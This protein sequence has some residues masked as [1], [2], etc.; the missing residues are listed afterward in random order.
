MLS[1]N[2]VSSFYMNNF[3]A[4]I[5]APFTSL[6][7]YSAGVI[8]QNGNI[9]KPESSID[10]FEYL[11]IKLKKIFAELP[12]GITKAKL[13]SYIPTLQ[14]FSEEAEGFGLDK[15]SVNLLI[16]GF[17]TA[18]TKGH[19]SY[20][21]LT[22]DM[23]SANLGGPASSPTANTG[24]V[25]GFDLPMGGI[26][27]RKPQQSVLGFEKQSCEMYDVCPEDYDLLANPNL[28]SWDEVPDSETK[29]FMQR[30]QRRNGGSTI[31]IRDTGTNR[32]H[33]VNLVPR[34]ISKM[35][36]NVDLS[37]FKSLLNEEGATTAYQDD[38][39]QKENN[40]AVET[41]EQERRELNNP[42]HVKKMAE[43]HLLSL[44]KIGQGQSKNASLVGAAALHEVRTRMAM[45]AIGMHEASLDDTGSKQGIAQDYFEEISHPS[46][47]GK[48]IN[49]PGR[50]FIAYSRNARRNAQ[51]KHEFVGGE[52]KHR[53]SGRIMIPTAPFLGAYENESA[54]E[55]AQATFEGGHG[56]STIRPK[57]ERRHLWNIV[58]P[59]PVRKIMTSSAEEEISRGSIPHS[60][61]V[62]TEFQGEFNP[63][64]VHG[65]GVS[66]FAK[67]LATHISG[68]GN[69]GVR[70]LRPTSNPSQVQTEFGEIKIPRQMRS[71]LQ[72]VDPTKQ[73]NIIVDERH[74]KHLRE[75][76]LGSS[77][78]E[79][80][81][82][83]VDSI[84]GEW[85]KELE[86]G[87]FYKP[88]REISLRAPQ[89]ADVL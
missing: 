31:I 10:P 28:K 34:N 51:G 26:L 68:Q 70:T 40:V 81:K 89:M 63:V 8:D 2:L 59:E 71:A 76:M 88:N 23:G 33:K 7:A 61:N 74:L 77:P 64:L 6:N 11:V 12:Y 25:T 32:Y 36:E 87:G 44:M 60:L 41:N 55:I 79:E 78:S 57:G 72:T 35:F 56:T 42:H 73:R 9:L 46:Y 30:S 13:S 43:G 85:T 14:L 47:I 29:R 22:E 48:A 83:D 52:S 4:A 80:H 53:P 5:A 38:P 69:V 67:Y 19:L 1:N 66:D 50:D 86:S 75:K 18:E 62:E 17:I 24:S 54:R 21:E 39:K 27:K 3:A 84:M 58:A 20:I 45:T 37:I 82:R 49:T 16:E 15:D 65:T